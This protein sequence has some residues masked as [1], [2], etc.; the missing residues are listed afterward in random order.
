MFYSSLYSFLYHFGSL[1]PTCSPPSNGK[2]NKP[3][4]TLL[5]KNTNLYKYTFK[6]ITTF[7]KKG[8]YDQQNR[9]YKKEYLK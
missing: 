7:F 9:R 6:K 8:K 1:K 4:N 3:N 2:A 5:L